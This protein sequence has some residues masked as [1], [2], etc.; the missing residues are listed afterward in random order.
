MPN[1]TVGKSAG[2]AV[3]GAPGQ[4][5]VGQAREFGGTESI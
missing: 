2:G 4:G 1:K 3:T 5:S